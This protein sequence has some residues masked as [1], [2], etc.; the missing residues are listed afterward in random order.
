MPGAARFT[1]VTASHHPLDPDADPD[2]DLLEAD[3]AA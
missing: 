3:H 2:I 1:P